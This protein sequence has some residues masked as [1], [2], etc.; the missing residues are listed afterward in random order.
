MEKIQF[1]TLYVNRDGL[2]QS[3][4][5]F[6]K[7]HKNPPPEH[8]FQ[9]HWIV[10]WVLWMDSAKPGIDCTMKSFLYTSMGLEIIK[11]VSR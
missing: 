10:S 4:F 11:Y 9:N 7:K 8:R 3:H 2:N 5:Y 6:I 1:A